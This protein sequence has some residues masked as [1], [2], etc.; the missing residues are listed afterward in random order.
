MSRKKSRIG[1]DSPDLGGYGPVDGDGSPIKRRNI[2]DSV[3][4]SARRTG[5]RDDRGGW[6]SSFSLLV[7]KLRPG[8]STA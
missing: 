5:D 3:K 4:S 2:T 8:I 7:C 1:D 6:F